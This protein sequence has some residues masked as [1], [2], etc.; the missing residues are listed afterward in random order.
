[1]TP[2]RV[3]LLFAAVLCLGACSGKKKKTLPDRTLVLSPVKL[4][5][6]GKAPRQQIRYAIPPDQT[7]R[8]VLDLRVSTAATADVADIFGVTPGFRLQLRA[9]PTVSLE[10]GTRYI[11]RVIKAEAM[12]QENT[13]EDQVDH[14]KRGVK[15]MEA[16]G[17]RLDLDDRGNVLSTDVPWH[18]EQDQIKP[19]LLT[20]LNNVRSA[21]ATVPFPKQP[22]GIGARW[23]VERGINIWGNRIN[24]V[25]TY[26]LTGRDG[27]VVEID[28][29]IEQIGRPQVGN[30]NP[31]LEIQL[32]S[33]KMEATGKATVDLRKP[34]ATTEAQSDA[35]GDFV[36]VGE[37]EY[38]RVKTRQRAVFR[39]KP[40]E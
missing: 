12:L 10:K 6:A 19:R 23:S 33:Y 14:I 13:P 24:Q 36:L 21:V 26:T 1:M 5:E 30:V 37:E 4:L 20:T 29:L 18:R 2:H 35:W 27:D 11:L 9:G 34:L 38:Q 17:G 16:I 3:L 32:A 25:I 15:A 8:A 39:L 40:T 28:L 22:V 31:N 7:S